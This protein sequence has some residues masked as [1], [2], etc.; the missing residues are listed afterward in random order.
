MLVVAIPMMP[1]ERLLTLDHLLADEAPPILLSQDLGTNPRRRLQSS[2]AVTV[3]DVRLPGRIERVGV[4]FDFDVTRRFDH[5]SNTDD[6]CSGGWSGEPPGCPR[7]LGKVA[8]HDPVPGCVRV[9]L[10]R[11][12]IEPSPHEVVEGSERLPAHDMAMIVRPPPQHGVQDSDE[13]GRGG[14]CGVRT[15]SFDPRLEGLEADRAGR[16]LE[17]A[18][19]AVGSLLVA[20]R[21]PSEVEALGDRGDDGLRR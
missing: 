20:A 6:P 11:P 14:P 5:L 7:L 8:I 12:P 16:H 17:L 15:K 9:A 19:L 4:P 13:R 21:L 10:L 18:P 3:L 2:L 1:F